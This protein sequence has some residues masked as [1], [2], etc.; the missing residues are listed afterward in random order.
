MRPPATLGTIRDQHGYITT[1]VYR[2]RD[3]SE[4]FGDGFFRT[5]PDHSELFAACS[6]Q[7]HIKF[8]SHIYTWFAK[9]HLQF[10]DLVGPSTHLEHQALT[11][12]TLI[13]IG[14]RY[15]YT[16]TKMRGTTTTSKQNPSFGKVPERFV[17]V[18]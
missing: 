18:S 4:P 11:N 8:R 17:A 9:I 10:G 14:F 16:A 12:H 1:Y 5:I 6:C 15:L 3:R 7:F 2:V 13:N